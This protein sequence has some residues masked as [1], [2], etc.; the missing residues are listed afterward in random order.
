MMT[1]NSLFFVA[2]ACILAACN[3]EGTPD[4]MPPADERVPLKVTS[5]IKGITRAAGTQWTAGDAIG[6]Y[7]FDTGSTAVNT[8]AENR[9]YIANNTSL[10]TFAPAADATIY[11]PVDAAEVDFIAYYPQTTLLNNSYTVA[12]DNQTNLPSIDLMRAAPVTQKSKNSP[13]VAFNFS[14]RLSKL[15]L[16]INAGTGMASLAGLA[17][18]ISG[19][20]TE[21]DYDVVS[22]VLIVDTNTSAS[23]AL[24]TVADGSSAE[25]ILLPAPAGT[26]RQLAFTIEGDSFF[27]DIPDTQAFNPGEKCTYTIT[28]NRTGIFVTSS[29]TDWTDGNAGGQA[30]DAE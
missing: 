13:E 27:W 17:V 11:F 19:Q 16:T 7:M 12:V 28:I 8:G 30:G 4:N 3:N 24:N 6:I 23:I 15:E 21:A 29:I 5:Q 26:G 1:K 10:G 14:H 25:A 2:A 20:Y 9:R 22:N 18:Q